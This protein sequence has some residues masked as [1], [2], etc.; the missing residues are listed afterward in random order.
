MQMTYETAVRQLKGIVGPGAIIADSETKWKIN[1]LLESLSACQ[2][3]TEHDLW[4]DQHG[5]YCI[6]PN[7][8]IVENPLY[9]VIYQEVL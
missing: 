8:Y 7:R 3:N 4:V 9:Q 6:G 1:T 5:I 2:D